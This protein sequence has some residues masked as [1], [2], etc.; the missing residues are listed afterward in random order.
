MDSLKR[1]IRKVKDL[2]DENVADY[3]TNRISNMVKFN[4]QHGRHAQ[5][6]TVTPDG[7]IISGT[8]IYI[9]KQNNIHL[10]K[11]SQNQKLGN[12]I[13]KTFT[14]KLRVTDEHLYS[15]NISNES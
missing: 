12:R 5:L 4:E 7:V 3:S 6:I 2:R 13:L 9:V 15:F 11:R 14:S 8:P 10:L 1:E